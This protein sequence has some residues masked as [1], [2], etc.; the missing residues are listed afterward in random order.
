MFT[1]A[2]IVKEILNNCCKAGEKLAESGDKCSDLNQPLDVVPQEL[3]SSCLYSSEICCS[4]KVRIEECKTGVLAAK[5]GKN[6]HGNVTEFYTS[7][8]ES[9]KVGLVVGASNIECTLDNLMY[10]TPFDDAFH[11]CCRSAKA[12]GSFYL[13]E[14]EESNA[15]IHSSYSSLIA[16]MIS[17]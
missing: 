13:Q 3:I 8:C 11:F 7:C 6:C 4:S 1:R 17:L 15:R 14:G 5:D 16:S 12:D 2:R 10:G 9:C